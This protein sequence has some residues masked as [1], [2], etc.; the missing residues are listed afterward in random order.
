M[1][2]KSKPQA[3]SVFGIRGA[4]VMPFLEMTKQNVIYFYSS[5]KIYFKSRAIGLLYLAEKGLK[6][7]FSA[8]Y[9]RKLGGMWVKKCIFRQLY[10]LFSLFFGCFSDYS[11]IFAGDMRC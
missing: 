8:N 4:K 9:K 11:C 3:C 5:C 7:A 6:K 10:R 2:N 1:N